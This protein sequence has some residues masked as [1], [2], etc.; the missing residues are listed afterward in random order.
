MLY[1]FQVLFYLHNKQC[2]VAKTPIFVGENFSKIITLV[3]DRANPTSAWTVPPRQ[4]SKFA[5][6][7]PPGS[8][9]GFSLLKVTMPR[10]NIHHGANTTYDRELQ[11][12]E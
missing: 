3:P 10:L 8:G 9:M 1:I 2:F 12:H 5:Q 6:A 11:R 4:I 7:W